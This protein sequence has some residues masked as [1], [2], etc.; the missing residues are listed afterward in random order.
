MLTSLYV[1]IQSLFATGCTLNYGL[2]TI[3]GEDFSRGLNT[4][5]PQV[6]YCPARDMFRIPTSHVT[7]NIAGS[8][9]NWLQRGGGGG[10]GAVFT[11]SIVSRH[12]RGTWCFGLRTRGR[13]LLCHPLS[14]RILGSVSSMD[15]RAVCHANIAMAERFSVR[16]SLA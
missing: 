15:A 10:G 14:P 9:V 3:F 1:C 4:I 7:A 11:S 6:K 5:C 16:N 12:T 8:N 13:A 2:E